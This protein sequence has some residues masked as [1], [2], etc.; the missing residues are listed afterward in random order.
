MKQLILLAILVSANSFAT[1][2]P[3]ITKADAVLVKKSEHR[4][5]LLKN[6]KAF[7]E[8]HVVFGDEPKGHKQREGDERTPE[9]RY[10]LDLKK[11]NSRYHRAIHISYPNDADKKR[12]QELGVKPGGAIMIHGQ[13]NGLAAFESVTQRRN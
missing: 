5:F 11:A 6:G 13:P 12:A 8:F 2:I 4:L 10:I 1:D 3:A 7:K 9:G